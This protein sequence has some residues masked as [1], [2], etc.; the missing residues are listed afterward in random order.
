MSQKMVDDEGRVVER[1][2]RSSLFPGPGEVRMVT[3]I[4]VRIETSE[5]ERDKKALVRRAV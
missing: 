3:H 4:G 1:S 2:R 5:V